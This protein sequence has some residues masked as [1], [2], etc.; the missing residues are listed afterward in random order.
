M[1]DPLI[2]RRYSDCRELLN[3]WRHYHDFFKIAVSGEAITPEKEHEFITI[4]S[5]IAMLHD[6][7]IDSLEQDQN[8][9]QNVLSIVTRSI[10]LKHIHRMSTAEIKKIELEWHESYLLLNETLGVLDDKRRQFAQVTPSV[11][12]REMYTKKAT[13]A[14]RDFI[15]SWV[16][17]AIV[18]LGIVMA[19]IIGFV[20]FGGGDYLFRNPTTRN[21]VLK[22]EDLIRV[23]Y[24]GYPYR[25]LSTV[26][27]M[28]A[29]WS[30]MF[31]SVNVGDSNRREYSK[32]TGIARV[33]QKMS[34]DPNNFSNDLKPATETR[35]EVYTPGF[36]TAGREMYVWHFLMPTKQAAS[37]I[38]NKYNAWEAGHP[39]PDWTFFR[40]NNVVGVAFG[41]DDEGQMRTWVRNQYLRIRTAKK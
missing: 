32:D 6:S 19:V 41:G 17:K 16:F 38:A 24:G 11:Y 8:I 22:F 37:S 13:K 36:Q 12:Y 21:L 3:L 20:Q 29:M 1:I 35:C 34:G 4:K 15:S 5:R 18:G 31:Q 2:E 26:Q 27:R 39:K 14:V 33:A 30:Q 9:G 7:F 23:V 40:L 25:E 10:T 28:D